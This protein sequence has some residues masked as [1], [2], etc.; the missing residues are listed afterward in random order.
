MTTHVKEAHAYS[1][2]LDQWV[3]RQRAAVS[4]LSSIGNLMY[5]HSIELV[6]FRNELVDC[7]VSEILNLHEYGRKTVNKP[8]DVFTSSELAKIIENLQ[9]APSKIDI[10]RLSNEWL[11]EQGDF[12]TKADFISNKLSN[13]IDD[14][15]F[16]LEPKDV[17]LFGFGLVSVG[18]AAFV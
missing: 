12:K 3:D 14:S 17:V 11:N 16:Q 8:I 4:L 15:K 13:I 10:G 5:N 1:Q 6:L 7:S 2:D 18:L 9:L